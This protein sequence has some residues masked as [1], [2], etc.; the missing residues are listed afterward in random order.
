MIPAVSK[1]LHV[2]S[3]KSEQQPLPRSSAA[4]GP[5]SGEAEN[6]GQS[7]RGV[8]GVCR[9]CLDGGPLSPCALPWGSCRLGVPSPLLAGP[10][11]KIHLEIQAWHFCP[12]G[13]PAPS[14]EGP[15]QRLG[16]LTCRGALGTVAGSGSGLAGDPAHVMGAPLPSALRDRGCWWA[17]NP[18]VGQ[19]HRG[20]GWAQPLGPLCLVISPGG[21]S[22]SFHDCHGLNVCVPQILA[23]KPQSQ[24]ASM[25]GWGLWEGI[26]SGGWG[27]RERVSAP[28]RRDPREPATVSATRGHS[29]K[30]PTAGRERV[31]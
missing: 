27:P 1:V 23:W 10:F 12:V 6:L 5:P 26:R 31:S 9:G 24:W 4:A 21:L 22:P 28:V 2:Q 14:P 25:W 16:R 30:A 13:D 19:D 17:W 3:W 8:K 20:P 7:V 29:S 18:V 15:R 11:W